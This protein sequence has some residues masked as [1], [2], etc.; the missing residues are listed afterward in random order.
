[1]FTTSQQIVDAQQQINR[2]RSEGSMRLDEVR[3]ARLLTLQE[4]CAA[5]G[6]VYVIS[7][8]PF[9]YMHHS[10]RICAFCSADEPKVDADA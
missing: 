1:M 8:A 4:Q 5:I 6:R 10:G 9:A 2:D 3:A 7:N